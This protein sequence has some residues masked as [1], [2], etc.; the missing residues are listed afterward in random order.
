MVETLMTGVN[1]PDDIVVRSTLLIT[2]FHRTERNKP[3]NA[4]YRVAN[5]LPNIGA[6]AT[7][8]RS[9][10]TRDKQ[11]T[12]PEHL[13]TACTVQILRHRGFYSYVQQ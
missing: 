13:A 4:D 1:T 12:V 5:T 11:G 2:R 6:G 7:C 3:I 9:R 10:K 8:R